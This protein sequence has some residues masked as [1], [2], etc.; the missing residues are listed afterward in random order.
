MKIRTY[1]LGII[2]T[3][4]AF[5]SS[6]FAQPLNVA[7]I[8][9][10]PFVIEENTKLTGFSIELWENIATYTDNSYSFAL[11]N[12][13]S[14]MLGLVRN[15]E[16]D[17]A[18]ANITITTERKEVMDFSDPF[19]ESGLQMMVPQNN[20]L[21]I[22]QR[23]FSST[24]SPQI[25]LFF[26]VLLIL[27]AH[28]LWITD[29]QKDRGIHI[30]YISGIFDSFWRLLTLGEFGNRMPKS[31]LTK[32]IFMAWIGVAGL[33]LTLFSGQVSSDITTH[34][35]VNSINTYHDIDDKRIG[36]IS[37]S[38]A[39]SFLRKQKIAYI[40]YTNI[41]Q[42]FTSLEENELDV[43]IHDFPVVQYYARNNGAGK[44]ALVGDIF[45]REQYGVALPKDSPLT[46]EINDALLFLQENGTYN[47]LLVKYFGN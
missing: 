28:I 31:I 44:V 24:E 42:M 21:G 10:Q 46:P 11:Q 8:E 2:I 22:L 23:L 14:D 25:I 45:Q 40:P 30:K 13:F 35:N 32:F 16:V 41:N 19:F 20:T 39:E 15:N 36:V 26:M 4:L 17:L 18:I 7:T 33:S 38:T 37:S 47:K 29:R 6:T 34:R 43:V 12:S 3:F 27:F 1:L 9:R 5:S